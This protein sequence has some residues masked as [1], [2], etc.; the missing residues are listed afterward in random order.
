MICLDPALANDRV[1]TR[2][3]EQAV[4]FQSSFRALEYHVFDESE[5]YLRRFSHLA[6]ETPLFYASSCLDRIL[7]MGSTTGPNSHPA[8]GGSSS[9]RDAH[10]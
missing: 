4:D 6:F 3:Q 1:L 10:Y 7:A 5:I 9:K 2:L 8:L